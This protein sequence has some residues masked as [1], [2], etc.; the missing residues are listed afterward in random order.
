MQLYPPV[1]VLA[2]ASAYPVHAEDTTNDADEAAA[3]ILESA[4]SYV[5]ARVSERPAP[6]YPG[7]ELRSRQEG[8]VE[9][10]F[11]IDEDGTP[12]NIIV[13]DSGGH[14]GFERAAVRAVEKWTYEPALAGGEPSWQSNNRTMI[15][16]A[17]DND[18]KGATRA[19]ARKYRKLGKLIDED[20]LG[21]ADALFRD[22]IENERLNLYELAMIW[23]QRV[24]YE[25]KTGDLLKLD[26][27]LH[28]ASASDGRWIDEKSYRA[29]L[30]VRVK[31][32]IQLG[33]YKQALAA[34]RD[35]E[36]LLGE[37]AP[38]VVALRPTIDT[39]RSYIDGNDVLETAAEIRARGG[40]YGCD[41]SYWFVP[42]RR[43]IALQEIDGELTSIEV[44]CTHKRYESAVS[45]EV[46]WRIPDSWGSCSI[47]VHGEPG[48]TFTVLALPDA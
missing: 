40:C 48:T 6:R 7:A 34:Y 9:V 8:W 32:E 35:L 37:D 43:T 21:E 18:T 19:I 31:V 11:C 12:Q 46:E 47:E 33:N 41:D 38:Q 25:G 15:S 29:L 5:P 17:L 36:K 28:R 44:R 10:G 13:L 14:R 16:F 20:K 42:A 27:A 22:L 24:R 30:E 3:A 26:L 23:S 4:R 2:L 1:L 45:D 39:L